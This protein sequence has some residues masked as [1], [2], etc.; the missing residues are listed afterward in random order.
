LLRWVTRVNHKD[1]GSLYFLFGLF[2]GI[3]GIRLSLIL[4]TEL[5]I[6]GSLIRNDHLYNVV[7]TA[8]AFIIIF[9]FQLYLFL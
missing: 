3:I 4:R 1:I 9:F 2:A 8:H 6:V 7:V 5:A